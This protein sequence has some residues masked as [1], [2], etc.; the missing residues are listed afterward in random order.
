[1][2]KFYNKEILQISLTL[3][4]NQKVVMGVKEIEI[5]DF[6]IINHSNGIQIKVKNYKKSALKDLEKKL[7]KKDK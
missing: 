6:I 3:K 5:E 4:D 1:M 7:R 2:N